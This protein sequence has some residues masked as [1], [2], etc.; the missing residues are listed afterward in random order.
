MNYQLKFLISLLSL[1]QCEVFSYTL[2]YIE[3]VLLTFSLL[4]I[5]L[6]TSKMSLPLSTPQVNH[7]T[8]FYVWL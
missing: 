8:Q 2:C 6:R 4:E 7:D 5:P 1:P 3:E